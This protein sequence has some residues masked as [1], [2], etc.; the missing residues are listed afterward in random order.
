MANEQKTKLRLEIAHVLFID[1]VGYSKLLIDEQS[2]ALQELNEIVRK[3][4]AVR[5]AEAAGQLIFLPT[6]DGMALVFT[7]SIENPVECALQ[8]SQRLRAQPSLLVRMGIH[9][10][11]VHH[12]ADVN[13]RENIA[14]AGI[15]IAQRVMD[16]GDAGHILVS[17]R[18]ADDL[19]QYRR[20]QP[21]LHE[22]GDFDAK[23]GAV[24]PVVHLYADVTGNPAVPEKFHKLPKAKAAAETVV[25]RSVIPWHEALLAILLIGAL[26][27]GVIAF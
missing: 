3:T 16:C 27:A 1:I 2:E 18:V 19:A 13:Q 11:P 12:V 26:I 14:G 20:W 17:K 21:Y 10:G 23:H 5:A 25:R 22:L 9:S 24:V 7:G 15:N 8:L 6:G 4:D